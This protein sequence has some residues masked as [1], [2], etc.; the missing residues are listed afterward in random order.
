MGG[1]VEH[2]IVGRIATADSL[3]ARVYSPCD[4]AGVAGK[5]R[6][7]LDLPLSPYAGARG[8]QRVGVTGAPKAAA[9]DLVAC[10]EG[11]G[12]ARRKPRQN[13]HVGQPASNIENRMVSGA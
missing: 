13:A 2:L 1:G 9:G 4:A 12:P 8:A 11:I 3:P 5:H 6:Q 10:I 7:R